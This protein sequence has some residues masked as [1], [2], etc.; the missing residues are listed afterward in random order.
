MELD[1]LFVFLDENSPEAERLRDGGLTE[2]FRR[3][4]QGQ[5]TANQCFCFDDFYLELLWVTDAEALEREPTR[6]TG[7]LE[8]S[9]WRET[10]ASPFGLSWRLDDK[11]D[12]PAGGFWDYKPAYLPNGGAIPV[13]LE[14]GDPRQPFLFQSPNNAAP[15]DWPPARHG[16]LQHDA[17]YLNL[18][19]LELALPAEVPPGP[20]LRSLAEAT[21]LR[22]TIAQRPQA[23]LHVAKS[24]GGIARLHLPAGV[25]S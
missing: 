10:V 11:K 16:G 5:G 15:R 14:S 13:A 4:H 21:Q 24:D 8:R 1:H 3:E 23:I 22:L 19:E 18:V 6:R 17:G 20:C 7:L 2:S 12:E 25:W 9:N